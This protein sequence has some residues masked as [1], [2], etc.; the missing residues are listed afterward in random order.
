VLRGIG[1]SVRSVNRAGCGAA[2]FEV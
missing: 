2:G 1:N